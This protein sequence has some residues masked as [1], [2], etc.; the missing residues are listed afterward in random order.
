MARPVR[1]V[2]KYTVLQRELIRRSSLTAA[3]DHGLL[4]RSHDSCAYSPQ[5]LGWAVASDLPEGSVELRI[6]PEADAERY[7]EHVLPLAT[8]ELRDELL[9]A[10]VVSILHEGQAHLPFEQPR[11]A[12]AA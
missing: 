8:A 4:R 2:R 5:V 1:A 7:L 10:M 3:A 9:H 6:A 12:R 11:E